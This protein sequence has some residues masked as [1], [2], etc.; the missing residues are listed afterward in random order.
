M[1][2][3]QRPIL[4][5]ILLAS[6]CA[7]LPGNGTALV[8]GPRS[9]PSAWTATPSPI[10][11]AT[12]NPSPPPT[13]AETPWPS[14][15]PVEIWQPCSDA[16]YSQLRLGDL[17]FVSYSPELPNRLRDS[18][19]VAR[20]AIVGR[21]YPGEQIVV[22]NGPACESGLLWWQVRVS[23]RGLVGWTAEGDD[24]GYWLLPLA[25]RFGPLAENPDLRQIAFVS[26]HEKGLD[27]YVM[28]VTITGERVEVLRQHRLTSGMSQASHPA[29]SPKGNEIAFLTD[30]DGVYYDLY[31]ATS[32]GSC[33]RLISSEPVGY[34]SPAWS[35][36]GD[37]LAYDCEF[38]ICVIRRDST[39]RRQL[40]H[41][42]DEGDFVTAPVW[43]ASGRAIAFLRLAAEIDEILVVDAESGELLSV[44]ASPGYQVSMD[45]SP[46]GEWI[47]VGSEA[48]SKG[49][50][51]VRPD[52]SE[53]RR[54]TDA[55]YYPS[56]SPDGLWLAYEDHRDIF[57]LDVK[58]ALE[59]RFEPLMLVEGKDF[60]SFPDWA[61]FG[62]P[63]ASQ[64][65]SPLS[66]PPAATSSAVDD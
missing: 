38:D 14:P 33:L 23:A 24:F 46:T 35:P 28:E 52:G 61:P 11:R 66:R 4:G 41:Q 27:L 1:N 6:G 34:S 65:A 22:L 32:D 60:A 54:L 49:I 18:P 40:T 26:N 25:S 45:W 16:P 37:Q 36:G 39:H 3:F 17:A 8:E 56:W 20:S 47:A 12:R 63:F 62:A 58:Q 59:G 29:W 48:P 64:V 51:L 7:R 30:R 43:S 5:L 2:P 21:A 9:L 13:F 57:L 53:T 42:Q 44:A 10:A 50:Y 55:G 15:Q 31:L 19:G